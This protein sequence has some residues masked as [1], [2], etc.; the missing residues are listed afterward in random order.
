[1]PI[2][3]YKCTECHDEF[4]LLQSIHSSENDT[5]CPRCFSKKL[6]KVV[7]AFSCATDSGCGDHSSI[8]PGGYG[9]GGG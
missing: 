1:M 5:E 8:H 7:S 4:S 2:Y 9:G 6:K 3:E